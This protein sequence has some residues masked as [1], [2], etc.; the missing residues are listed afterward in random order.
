[1]DEKLIVYVPIDPDPEVVRRHKPTCQTF[2][3]LRASGFEPQ[4]GP[5][6]KITMWEKDGRQ[7]LFQ[8]FI[9]SMRGRV[10]V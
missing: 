10:T 4:L 9:K 1:M 7:H 3:F 6:G 8:I 5:E 2:Q